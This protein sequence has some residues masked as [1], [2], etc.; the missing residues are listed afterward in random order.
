MQKL[1]QEEWDVLDKLSS[2]SKMDCWFW[3]ETDQRGNNFVLDQESGEV[4]SLYDG[5]NQLAEGLTS[6]DDY[7][8]TMEEK[9]CFTTL[10]YKL[11]LGYSS[12]NQRLR[13]LLYNAILILE[14]IWQCANFDDHYLLNSE[15]GITEEEYVDIMGKEFEIIDEDIDEPEDNDEDDENE[16]GEE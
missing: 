8:L 6:L 14:E 15:I 5:I 10:M 7:G 12:N 1:T 16:E 4:M 2:K 3:I 9:L 11:E 13:N